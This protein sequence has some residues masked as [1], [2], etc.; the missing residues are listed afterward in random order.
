MTA[1]KL[2]RV[3]LSVGIIPTAGTNWKAVARKIAKDRNHENLF[4]SPSREIKIERDFYNIVEVRSAFGTSISSVREFSGN[5]ENTENNQGFIPRTIGTTDTVLRTLDTCTKKFHIHPGQMPESRK[6][7]LTD[8]S[9]MLD[10]LEVLK[11]PIQETVVSITNRT[12]GIGATQFKVFYKYM[13]DGSRCRTSKSVVWSPFASETHDLNGSR[14][15]PGS[16]V[17]MISTFTN[18]QKQFSNKLVH[19]YTNHQKKERTKGIIIRTRL[20]PIRKAPL[21]SKEDKETYLNG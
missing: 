21:L 3:A 13:K 18:G 4:D 9:A 10:R 17:N 1:L 14:T 12:S 5:F 7:S 19:M 20:D 8:I 15:Q 6:L 16:R 2:R 11:Q